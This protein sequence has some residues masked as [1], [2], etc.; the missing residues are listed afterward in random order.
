MNKSIFSDRELLKQLCNG[1]TEAFKLLFDQYYPVLVRVLMRY[2]TD[3]EEIKDWIQEIYIRLW[4]SRE[5]IQVDSIDNFKAYFIVT[6]RNFAIKALAKKRKLKTE[7]FQDKDQEEIADN[8]GY[9]VLEEVEL[10]QA[11]HAVISRLPVKTRKAYVLN[12]ETG[13]TYKGVAEELGISIKTV[14]AQI[15]RAISLLRQELH[16]FLQ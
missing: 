14:E 15:S 16:V 13:L 1:S 5:E 2:S 10:R 12:R 9:N 11:Y 7:Q 3:Q 8:N 4:E 6:A